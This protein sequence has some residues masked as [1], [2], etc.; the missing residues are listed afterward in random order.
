MKLAMAIALVLLWAS[1][2]SA[3]DVPNEYVIHDAH[4]LPPTSDWVCAREVAPCPHS[5]PNRDETLPLEWCKDGDGNYTAM[6]TPL[7][8]PEW[9]NMSTA[10]KKRVYDYSVPVYRTAILTSHTGGTFLFTDGE[11]LLVFV[12]SHYCGRPE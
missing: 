7:L 2:A 5:H 9:H 10:I 3:H 12:G 6:R 4:C 11:R 1:T 8:D